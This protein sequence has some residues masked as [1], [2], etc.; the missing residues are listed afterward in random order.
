MEHM[1]NNAIAIIGTAC[2][3]PGNVANIEEF[4]EFLKAGGDAVGEVPKERWSWQFH[5]DKNHDK[6]GKSYVN[7]GSPKC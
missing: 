1:K 4:W 6:S 3:L 5:Y 2:R 7:R